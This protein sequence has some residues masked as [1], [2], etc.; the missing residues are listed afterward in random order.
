VALLVGTCNC[1]GGSVPLLGSGML[2]GGGL[3][4][5]IGISCGGGVPSPSVSLCAKMLEGFVPSVSFFPPPV[6]GSF[7]PPVPVSFPSVES[8]SIVTVVLSPSVGSPVVTVAFPPGA[9]VVELDVG[10]V[11]VELDVGVVSVELDV[12]VVSVEFD[13]DVVSVELGVD[14]VSVELDVVAFEGLSS[15]RVTSPSGFASS[16]SCRSF[17]ISLPNEGTTNKDKSSRT[18]SPYRAGRRANRDPKEITIVME[19]LK[20]TETYASVA[21]CESLI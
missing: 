8:G 4:P 19:V 1:G 6:A 9:A 20:I 13:V 12:G 16:C 7:S 3:V 10:V 2:I 18:Q 5:L 11:S 15:G 17:R 21:A 14:V